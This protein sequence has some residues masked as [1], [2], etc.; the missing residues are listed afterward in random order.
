MPRNAA[1]PTFLVTGSNGQVGFELRR[2]LAP[3]GKVVALDR[4][5]CDLTRPD[6]IRRVVREHQ[7]D[8]IVNP[9]AYTAVDKAESEPELAYAI[10]G[11]AVEVL[12]A[13]AKAL[14]SL[15]VHY[16]TDY[17]FDG[18]KA[19]AYI[20][21]DAVNP[22]SVYGKSK[23]AGEQAIAVAGAAH[24]VFRT[25]WVA[26]AHGGNFAKTMLK[27]GRERDSLRVIADQ[28]GAPTT[29]ALI[30]DVT[31]QVVARH[32]LSGD[33]TSFASG[34]YHL[35]AAG[36]TTWHAYASEVLRYAAAK[37][38]ELKVDPARIEPIPATAYPLPAPRPANSRLD[39][40][41]LRQ[42]FG[43]HLPDWQQGVHYLL[44][45]ILS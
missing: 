11:T 41:K 6:D 40:S 33:R 35:A 9:A 14:G 43:I 27:L 19:G 44:D 5:S 24:L 4:L 15:L 18:S 12:A 28:F 36:E 3:L 38:I 8:V 25:C 37:G 23:L 10:N 39:T 34:S 2:S 17:V 30:A 42:T 31:A 21:T 29:A 22:Q 1:I 16:S 13:E 45:Q 26:G 32:W 20:E 7:P